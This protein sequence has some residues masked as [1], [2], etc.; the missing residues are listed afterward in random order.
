MTPDKE[1]LTTALHK[2]L[3]SLPIGKKLALTLGKAY[4]AKAEE[5]DKLEREVR[6]IR[7]TSPM[8]LQTLQILSHA[9]GW[10]GARRNR[11]HRNRYTCG[12]DSDAWPLIQEMCAKGYMRVK[13][14]SDPLFGGM[15]TFSVTDLGI[16]ELKK[17][18]P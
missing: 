1:S 5:C 4:L 10:D 2:A 11:L 7:T 13:I 9:A 17:W 8:N 12:P 16:A 14:P 18:R 15:T 3:T 6:R